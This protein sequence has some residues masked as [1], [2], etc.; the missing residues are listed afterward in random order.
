LSFFARFRRTPSARQVTLENHLQGTR[1]IAAGAI[2]ALAGLLVLGALVL[3]NELTLLETAEFL[4][5]PAE[6]L[7]GVALVLILPPTPRQVVATF[8]G[9][10][11]GLLTIIK[12]VD[13]GFFEV[14]AR[15][16]DPVLDWTFVE[17][18]VE[19][20]TTSVGRAGAIGAVVAV[21][22]LVVAILALMTL[23]VL[24][25][26]RVMIHHDTRAARA[27]AALGAV[28]ATCAMLGAEVV[29]GVPVASD[30]AAA[31]AYHHALQIGASL[32]DQDDF[33]AESAVDAFRNTPGD[34]L[35]TGLRGKDVVL[36]FVE[37]YGRDAID[38]PEMAPQVDAVLEDGNR[39]LSAAGFSSRSAFL[40]SPTAGG[41][42]WLAH[43]T[44]L[45]GLWI[46][47]QQRYR[48]LVAS[49]RLT[50]NGAFR[51]ANWQS[52]AVVPGV[53]RAWPE[54]GFF[55]YDRIYA[56]DNLGY[57][58]PRFSWATMPDQYTLSAFE[59]LERAKPDHPPLMAEIPLLSSHAPW[60]P[61]PKAVGWDQVGDGSVFNS[62]AEAGAPPEAILS[63]DPTRVRADYRQSIEY[64]LNN[65]ISYVEKYG[66]ENL[67]LVFLGDHQPAPIV[68]GE[69]AN[70]DVPIT[71]VA[72]DPAVLD[73]I[74]GWGWQ[75]GIKPGP[76]APVWPM[77][78]FRDRFLTAF[79]SRAQ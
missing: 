74:S 44:L 34:Q 8:L 16:F 9:V 78:S 68:T 22:V 61:L 71:I 6:A 63:R 27:I 28:W 41:G 33:A 59:R 23:A 29:P 66:D 62:M 56:A 57:Q 43:S 69:D 19:F 25:L 7:V 26:T 51:R 47:N 39:R 13:M 35:L 54:A 73:Q 55:G 50:L 21:V 58:G 36:A 64:S 30:S 65:L 52:V 46:D 45:S 37:S 77:S 3:P 1:P 76:Q 5:I 42:S 38:D 53:T 2:T 72:R 15:P 10:G 12:F 40:T 18:G 32:Q 49:D 75:T 79:G 4:R 17:N 60:S 67:V 48:T 70:H 31:I 20:L 11:L 14:L 24:R